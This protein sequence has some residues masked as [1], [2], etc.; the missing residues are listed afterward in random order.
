MDQGVNLAPGDRSIVKTLWES[1]GRKALRFS[2][3]V[4]RVTA[5]FDD[6]EIALLAHKGPALSQLLYGDPAQRQFDDLD[7]LIKPADVSRARR[8]LRELG[9]ESRLQLSPRQAK[10]YLRSG[11]EYVFGLKAERNLLELQWQILPRFYSVGF[12]MEELF[13]RFSE[14]Q[15][16]SIRLRTL[17]QADLLLVL[18]VHAA[19][20]LWSQLG[21]VRDIATLASFNLDWEWI[22]AEARRLGLLRIVGVSLLLAQNLLGFAAPRRGWADSDGIPELARKFQSDLALGENPDPES[23][24]YFHIIVQLRERWR[25]RLGFGWHLAC[26]P[27]VG[28]WE[29][30]T[31][32]DALYPLYRGVRLW[33]LLR[34]CIPE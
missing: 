21:M 34:R 8:A 32:P 11:Y 18:C 9:Y 30:I 6:C 7:F 3:E 10:E 5:H 26:I 25:D 16:E 13:S 22:E 19:K 23:L 1:H 15:F 4:A 28:E 27:S 20:H 33:R 31:L 17:G 14:V 24:R 2:A 29:T 12:D